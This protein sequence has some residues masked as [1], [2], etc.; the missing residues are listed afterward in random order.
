MDHPQN[1][2]TEKE[3]SRRDALKLGGAGL[4]AVG[5]AYS[6]PF[7]ETVSA[8]SGVF[9]A[10]GTVPP[11]PP[12]PPPEEVE[13]VRLDKSSISVTDVDGTARC[14]DNGDGTTAT[15]YFYIKN[16]GDEGMVSSR[17]YYIYYDGDDI[18]NPIKSGTFQLAKDQE[19][20]VTA[21]VDCGKKVWIEAEQQWG[22]PPID[23]NG[24]KVAWFRCED[25]HWVYDGKKWPS[26]S[27]TCPQCE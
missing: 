25:D 2:L 14:E 8:D 19:I 12:P 17:T 7:V 1:E 13:C 18:N 15:V 9:D 24:T 3:I 6:K 22:H 27:V 16:V 11:P 5:L 23:D 21:V 4:V 20:E 26:T 10:Y